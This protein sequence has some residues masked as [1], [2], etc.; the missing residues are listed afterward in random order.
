MTTGAQFTATLTAN[1]SVD[2]FTYGWPAEQDVTWLIVP[3]TVHC[4]ATTG[5][6]NGVQV[7]SYWSNNDSACDDDAH[8]TLPM[9]AGSRCGTRRVR[10]G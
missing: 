7:Q 8:G 9:A 2:F 10:R 6:L 1:Q 3:T 5:N 4:E